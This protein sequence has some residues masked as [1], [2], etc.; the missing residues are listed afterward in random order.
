MKQYVIDPTM[1]FPKRW[2]DSIGPIR[3]M[4]EPIEGYLMCRRP[5]GIPF[6]LSV[7]QILNIKFCTPHGPFEIVSKP[8]KRNAP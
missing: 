6:I 3:V 5:R 8:T 7:E 1:P 4:S 2:K